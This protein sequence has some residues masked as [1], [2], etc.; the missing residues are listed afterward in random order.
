M[1][2]KSLLRFRFIE[3]GLDET[4]SVAAVL[5]L[6]PPRSNTQIPLR[7]GLA[8]GDEPSIPSVRRQKRSHCAM[9]WRVPKNRTLGSRPLR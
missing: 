9:S 7:C 5:A 4:S 2:A 8:A 6:R 1:R 3:V